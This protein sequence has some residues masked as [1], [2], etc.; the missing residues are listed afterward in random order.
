MTFG[1]VAQFAHITWPVVSQQC[2]ECRGVQ[3]WDFQAGALTGENREVAKQLQDVFCVF[4]QG[5]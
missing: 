1:A 4:T 5:R 2:L 3:G